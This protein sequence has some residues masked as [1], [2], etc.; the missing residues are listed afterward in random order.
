MVSSGAAAGDNPFPKSIAAPPLPTVAIKGLPET[1]N[2]TL[3]DAVKDQD[4]RAEAKEARKTPPD[5]SGLKVKTAPEAATTAVTPGDPGQAEKGLPEKEEGT[6]K[7]TAGPGRKDEGRDTKDKK[8]D[9][10]PQEWL[11]DR[12][13]IIRPRASST[14]N[15]SGKDKKTHFKWDSSEQEAACRAR[16]PGLNHHL[17]KARYYSVQGDTCRTG[18]HASTFLEIVSACEEECP[19]GFLDAEGYNEGIIRNLRVLRELGEKRC[20]GSE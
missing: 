12:P 18:A 19:Q 9:A 20:L 4:S 2:S 6:G 7:E 11:K 17:S 16:L 1:Q 5:P 10:G 14:E 8:A 15:A 13:W 3:K